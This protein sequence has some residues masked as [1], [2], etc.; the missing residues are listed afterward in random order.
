[1]NSEWGEN[2]MNGAVWSVAN[3]CGE[4]SVVHGDWEMYEGET[5]SQ[6]NVKC[7]WRKC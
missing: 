5:S 3:V 2:P 1:M 6:I 4:E 7:R